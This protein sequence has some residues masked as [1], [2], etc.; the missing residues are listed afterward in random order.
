MGI[1]LGLPAIDPPAKVS[2]NWNKIVRVSNTRATTQIVASPLLLRDSSVH[3][4]VYRALRDL[5]ADYVRYSAWFPFPRIAVAELKPPEAGKT[6][7]DFSF[8]DPP[9]VDFLGATAGHPVILNLATIP[10][11]MFR[12]NRPVS[13]PTDPREVAYDYKQGT[14]LRDPSGKEVAAYFARLARWYTKGKFEDE[15]GGR[16]ASSHRYRIEYWEVLNEPDLEHRL[17]PQDYTTLYDEIVTAVRRAAPWMK[18]VG[19][20]LAY[21]GKAPDFFEYFLDPNHHKPGIPLDMISY[22]FYAVPTQ[23]QAPNIHQFTFFEQAD[24]FVDVVRYVDSIRRRVS[25]RTRTTINEIG[26]ILP[27]YAEN[28]KAS[29][30]THPIYD[31]Y[32]NL[33]G[34]MFAYL[35]AELA[36]LGID[37]VGESSMLG[38]PPQYYPSVT[39]V[40]WESGRPN[41]RYWILKMLIENFKPP[42]EIVDTHVDSPHIFALGFVTSERSRKILLINKRLRT[43]EV[44]LNGTDGGRV[45][46]VDQ[47]RPFEPP[48]NTELRGTKLRL[49]GY[50]VAVVTLSPGR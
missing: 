26:S 13:F 36:Y 24:R 9:I 7:W 16:H 5:N 11:W 15:Y 34:A 1:A 12:T 23:D 21:P 27:Q 45:Q 20:S 6:F 31:A 40:D 17:S 50:S 25:P 8:M 32:W 18:F 4:A 28:M 39:M 35:Y 2:V 48:A 44:I 38:F 47:T 42:Y 30:A 37:A 41:A 43:F 14:R 46:F 29:Y 3:D 49:Q 19:I 33:S 10:Q 22:H